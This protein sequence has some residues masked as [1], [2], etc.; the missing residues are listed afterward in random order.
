M[1]GRVFLVWEPHASFSR[2]DARVRDLW[3]QAAR[4]LARV[5]TVDWQRALPDWEKPQPLNEEVERWKNVLRH[6]QDPDW[7]AAG[8]ELGALLASRLPDEA[9]VGVIHGDFQPGNIL[10]DRRSSRWIDRLGAGLDRRARPRPRLDPDDVRQRGVARELA[11]GRSGIRARPDRRLSRRRRPG[12]SPS[13]MV[14]G[15]GALSSR[16][17]SPASMSN[18]I[19]PASVRTRCGSASRLRFRLLFARGIELAGRAAFAI[20]R[21]P[22]K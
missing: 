20:Q 1:P 8:T 22:L 15:A 10:Y 7:L 6:A 12:L 3:L 18:F 11:A 2:D 21:E 9:P 16:V 13:R 14:S 17:R 4:L 5:H 19:A